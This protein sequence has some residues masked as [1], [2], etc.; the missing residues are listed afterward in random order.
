MGTPAEPD[1]K[2]YRLLVENSLGL[3]CIHDIYGV[4]LTINPAAA[5]SLGYRVEECCGRSIRELLAPSV[6]NLFDDYLRRIR[7]NSID[8]GIMRLQ[9]KDGAERLWLYRNVLYQE[10]GSPIRVL[11]HAQDVTERIRAERGLKQSQADLARA[12]DEL[13]L[14]VA[15]RTVELQQTNE[16]LRSEVEQRQKIEEE[17]LR[18]RKLEAIG[19]L[20][21][22]LAHDFNNLMTIVVG[23]CE[24]MRSEL[25][26]KPLLLKQVNAIHKAAEQ[27]NS[28]TR[29]L[30]AFSRR[31]KPQA[32]LL[33]LND[34][35]HDMAD[36]LHRLLT[37]DIE[38]A[39][40]ADPTLGLF[41]ADRGQIEQVILNLVINAADAMPQGGRLVIATTNVRSDE[42]C[43]QGP[44]P[45]VAGSFV[46]L[47][48]SDSGIGMPPE[49]KARIFD[50]FFT[51]KE[52]GKGTG[53]GLATVY[54]IV[55]Q[56]AGHISVESEPGQGT[57][58]HILFPR[59]ENI[60]EGSVQ[61]ETSFQWTRG[62]ET[63]LV[64]DDQDDV[65][66]L[67][68][69]VLRKNG[70]SVLS[71]SNGREALR[72][73][74][75]HAE[76]IDLIITDMVMPQMGGREL[77]E[78]LRELQSHTKILYMSG[79]AERAEDLAELLSHGHAFI[80]K[81][82]TPEA[83]LRKIRDVLFIEPLRSCG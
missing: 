12:R 80:E 71:A 61:A 8:S 26:G 16:R 54:G 69:E 6:Q 25:A 66:D 73:V 35:L 42:G 77:A 38:V 46:R 50:P 37:D 52:Q 14:R 78:A 10:P 76:P 24:S 43:D 32:G 3:M 2:L 58:F 1:P 34:V 29:Q 81:P 44:S 59:C 41:H 48:V 11:G 55:Q 22:G 82:F 45:W 20:A 15:E 47:T 63:V 62:S 68:C 36:M 27:A 19:R 49:I 53:L 31:Q 4:L 18:T 83:L 56:A 70:Y 9:A 33:S 60:F 51:T 79:Y 72:L 39:M 13:E 57:T 74:R 75:E 64:V 28:L 23:Y 65:R 67:L 5:Q 17:L 21:G 40:V 30:L 7:T